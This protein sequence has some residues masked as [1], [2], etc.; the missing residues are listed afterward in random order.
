MAVRD[1]RIL[2]LAPIG[3]DSEIAC[4][5]L[6]GAGFPAQ[7]CRTLEEVLGEMA[8]GVGVL[9]LAEEGL[10]VTELPRLQETIARQPPWS[11]IP[12][13]ILTG[14]GEL[15]EARLN[16]L[17]AFAPSGNV[18][19]LE[20][21][22][23]QMTLLSILKMAQ[24]AR[25]RQYQ[26]RGTL[27]TLGENEER[28]RLALDSGKIG[29]WEWG[30]RSDRFL[31]SPR[32]H[33]FLGL[34]DG[35]LGSRLE[36][37][38][39]RIHP[40]DSR[41]FRDTVAWAVETGNDCEM[42]FRVLR[43]E[44][45]IRWMYTRAKVFRDRESRPVRLIGAAMDISD[46]KQVEED[47][48]LGKETLV[49]AQK[50]E[51]IGK[52][53]GGI[54]HDFNNMLTAI[55]GYSELLMGQLHDRN[56]LHLGLS[57]ILR[58]GQRAA[59][60][61]N[62]LL[63]YSRQQIMA[64]RLVDVNRIVEGMSGM[65]KRLLQEDIE[66]VCRLEPQL[67]SIKA[68][69]SQVEQVILNLALNARDAMPMG[70]RL[71][72]STRHERRDGRRDPNLGNVPAG[73]YVVLSV[74]DS[75]VGMSDEVKARIFEPFFTTKAVGKG[76]GMGLSTVY[77]IVQ[78]TGAHIGVQ[79][80]PGRG[81]TFDVLFPVATG[82]AKEEPDG[83]HALHPSREKCKETL[84]VAEDEASV[85]VFLRQL[86]GAQ[87]YTVIE[88]GNG[89]EALAASEGYAGEIHLLITDVVMPGM[90][91]R[92][93]AERLCRKRTSMRVL[94]ISGYTDDAILHHGVLDGE[95]AFMNKP[96]PPASLLEK[97]RELLGGNHAP[98]PAI[99]G[100]GRV[101]DSVRRDPSAEG[102]R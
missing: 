67:P 34:L 85:R 54:A 46:R 94:F 68:D 82:D 44:G 35:T 38:M 30:I 100:N 88:A 23:R 53:A 16:T 59:A 79:S 20:R 31:A 49:Q 93:L 65:L 66:H 91:G 17:N 63:A 97:V 87:G 95:T 86:L 92:E 5:V 78:Q 101:P 33:E 51:A 76:T 77:G 39:A 12:I 72:I 57:E 32:L 80:S 37:F 21:P 10:S 48:R 81:S 2:V 83:P 70:G 69:P 47:L 71:E 96:F 36:S 8:E 43:P 40:E 73:H 11:D 55:N 28:L 29:A 99:K 18:T 75:G 9:L 1:D 22:F 4:S 7:A 98:G 52:L 19:F 27:F 25:Q 3:R 45:G 14:S 90:G 56:A 61:T 62:Q 58:S 41:A 50:M 6:R 60:L 42:E 15:N 102:N 74:R 84:L 26:L 24:R 64:F 13:V 89:H